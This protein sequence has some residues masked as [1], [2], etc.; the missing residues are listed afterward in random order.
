MTSELLRDAPIGV[1]DSG[2][3]GLTVVREMLTRLPGERI[4]YVADQTH[5]PYGGRDLE[6]VRGFAVGISESLLAW[7]CKAVAMACNISSAVAL[8]DVQAA[9]PA[10]PALGVI[11]PGA[12]AALAVTETA[13]SAFWRRKARSEAA[14]TPAPSMLPARTFALSRR[15]V[16]SS[17]RWWKMGRNGRRTPAPPPASISVPSSNRAPTP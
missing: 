8:A 17:C 9:H 2:L 1:F 7:G 12:E 15:P 6:E 13:L 3:G 5:V 16:R 10:L 4:I 11:L 14:P